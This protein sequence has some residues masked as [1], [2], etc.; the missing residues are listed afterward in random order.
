MIASNEEEVEIA[1]FLKIF[2][3]STKKRR[4]PN[5]KALLAIIKQEMRPSDEGLN[6]AFEKI[7]A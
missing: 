3:D 4:L 2:S 5:V 6:L 7:R 1:D